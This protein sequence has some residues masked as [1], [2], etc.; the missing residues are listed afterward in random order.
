VSLGPVVTGSSLAE[1][2]VVWAEELSE[3]AGADRV[4]G[5]WLQVEEDSTGNISSSSGLVE[6]DVD[7]LEL[8]VRVSVVCASW[9]DSVLVGDNLP[10]LGSDLVT[11]LASL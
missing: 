9:V 1:D 11:A 5:A 8:E 10:E 7:A 2:E 3:G 4:H 6:V